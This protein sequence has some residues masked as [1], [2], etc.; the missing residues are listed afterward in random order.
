MLSSSFQEECLGLL[1]AQGSLYGLAVETGLFKNRFQSTLARGE[2]PAD[3][4]AAELANV[5]FQSTLARG[6]RL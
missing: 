5:A 3:I 1:L 2:R 6:E 4:A